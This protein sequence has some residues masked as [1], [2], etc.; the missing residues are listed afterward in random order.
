M[1][2]I[3]TSKLAPVTAQARFK[4]VLEAAYLLRF[5]LQQRSNAEVRAEMV[6]LF[7]SHWDKPNQERRYFDLL[8]TYVKCHHEADYVR[9]LLKEDIQIKAKDQRTLRTALV[10]YLITAQ[11]LHG[12]SEVVNDLG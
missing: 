8:R 5:L 9:Y 12:S 2:I 1:A 3:H 4:G 6:R 7:G 10:R 11:G